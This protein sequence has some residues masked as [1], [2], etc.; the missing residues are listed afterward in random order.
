MIAIIPAL[1]RTPE[2]VRE[3]AATLNSI[4]ADVVDRCIVAWKGL[5]PVLDEVP[6][7]RRY[8][9]VEGDMSTTKWGSIVQGLRE[10]ESG[11]RELVLLIDADDPFEAESLREFCL[12]AQGAE[13]DCVVGRRD[14][15][16]LVAE[17]QRT[18][19]TRLYIEVFSNALLLAKLSGASGPASATAP[20]TDKESSP[21]RGSHT[22]GARRPSI[23]SARGPDIQSGL[24]VLRAD[25][26]R[27]VSFDGVQSYG[28]E[29]TLYHNLA[30]AGARIEEK[31]T[32]T[33]EVLESSYLSRDIFRA[34]LNLP[35]FADA[36]DA[37]MQLAL[38]EGARL[39]AD[40]LPA[41]G[42]ADY[43]A[44]I[45]ALLSAQPPITNVESSRD[46]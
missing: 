42:Y 17:D 33:R 43:R 36:T 2:D 1:L 14:R 29:L 8:S 37:D 27:R 25:V 31:I 46:P 38:D 30:K 44:E 35:F 41:G 3:L 18:P 11:S 7:G 4:P 6:R 10:V 22:E 12:C 15:V 23:R 5:R 45:Q 19:L 21:P 13:A 40:W 24:Y 9:L 20:R 39:Y 28:G 16:I 32:R 34:I 26:L